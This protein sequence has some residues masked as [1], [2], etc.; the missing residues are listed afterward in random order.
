MAGSELGFVS[1]SSGRELVSRDVTNGDVRAWS[2]F[3]T[4]ASKCAVVIA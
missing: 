1:G 3:S 2:S 4:A